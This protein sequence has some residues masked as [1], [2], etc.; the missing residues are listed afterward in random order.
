M[1][2]NRGNLA[3]LEHSKKGRALHLFRSLGQRKG[4]SYIGEFFYANHLLEQGPDRDG[5]QRQLI[6]FQLVPIE[7]A[8]MSERDD[9]GHDDASEPIPKTLAEARSRAI[10]AA[11]ASQ[12]ASSQPAMRT[13]YKRSKAVKYYVLLRSKGVCEA[14]KT[15]APFARLDG[16]PYL[17]PHHTTRVSDGGPDHPRYVAAICPTCHSEIHYGKN[18]GAKNIALQILLNKLETA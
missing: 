17:E 7:A 4:Q 16:T 1:E 2:F 9:G 8:A 6:I 3:I 10:D 12:G 13:L 15:P 5:N 18:G 14:C 11:T